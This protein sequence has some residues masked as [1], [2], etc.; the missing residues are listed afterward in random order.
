MRGDVSFFK[1][2]HASYP[3]LDL[4]TSVLKIHGTFTFLAHSHE[5]ILNYIPTMSTTEQSSNNDRS[6][7][8]LPQ[9]EGRDHKT[10]T[11]RTPKIIPPL[12]FQLVA[13]GVYRSGYPLEFNYPML[14]RLGLRSVIYLADQDYGAENV[15]W[16]ERNNVQIF[17]FR[18]AAVK[19]PFIENDP[20][21]M[22]NALLV[23]LDKRNY[24]VLI[25]SNKG[26]HRAGVLVGCM[27]KLL[28]RWSLAA[29]HAEYGRYAGE[30]GEA[31][32]EFIE[33]FNPTLEYEKEFAPAWLR[34]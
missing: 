26:K 11:R 1:P 30:K 10:R 18:V 24:P 15:A 4:V 22:K 14:E 16:C 17:H 34:I 28:Q 21:K 29:A 25:H 31:D 3:K 5:G 23:L 9:P 32:L 12:S 19:E 2:H 8:L 13:T 27:R 6:D 33:L 7:N 20:E